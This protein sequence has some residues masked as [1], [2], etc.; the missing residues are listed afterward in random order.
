[1][2]DLNIVQILILIDIDRYSQRPKSSSDYLCNVINLWVSGG[3]DKMRPW[4]RR[5]M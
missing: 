2:Y 1:M 5:E 4:A 3:Y